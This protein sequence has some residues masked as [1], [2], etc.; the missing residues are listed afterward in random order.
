MVKTQAWAVDPLEPNESALGWRQ[1]LPQQLLA[2]LPLSLFFPVGVM[3]TGVLLFYLSVLLSGGYMRKILR[4]RQSPM[5]LPILGLSLVSIIIA[6]MEGAPEG[7]EK[8]FWPGFWH[9]QTYLF[10]LPFL[11]VT[12]GFWQRRAIQV[13]FAGALMAATLF[14][15]NFFHLL[16]LNTLFRSYVVY[17][18]NKSILLAILLA[19]AAAWMIEEMRVQRNH[20]PLRLLACAF[21]VLVLI[22]L[23]KSRTAVLLFLILCGVIALRQLGW[24][25]RT[26]LLSLVVCAGVAGGWKYALS[27]PPPPTCEVRLVQDSPWNIFKLRSIC[28]VQQIH[29]SLTGKKVNEDGM[30]LDIYRITADII[31]EEPVFGHG[32]ASWMPL[33]RER[34][35]G[36]SSATMTTPHNDYLLYLTELGLFGLL[37]LLLIWAAQFLAAYRLA[38]HD[39]PGVREMA[40]PLVMLTLAMM[41]GGMF[42]AILRDGVFG[43]AFMILLSIPLAGTRSRQNA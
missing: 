6:A 1:A 26:M 8:E 22:L 20:L 40:M 18:G 13:F 11:T 36:L 17:E 33:Y 23:A 42:N 4:L 3:Y 27:L 9:Y 2:Y 10:L 19:V 32:I 41:V 43:M 37:A 25:W 7:A 12:T 31:A 5:L 16:P 35:A 38:M 39:H 24:S 14:V 21:V 29:D 30:R 28:T 15:A 34:A